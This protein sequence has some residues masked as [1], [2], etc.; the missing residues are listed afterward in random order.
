MEITAD[1]PCPCRA[2]DADQASYAQ[3]CQPFHEHRASGQVLPP[4]AEQLMRSRY[5]AFVLGLADYLLQSWHET[6][7]PAE[8]LLD[9]DLHWEGLDIVKTRSGGAQSSRGVVEFTAHYSQDG[10]RG[11]QHE[12]STFVRENGAWFYLDALY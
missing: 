4:T 9:E 7:R 6:T 3:C 5:S 12:V 2:L 11:S 8:L 10:Q 1:S